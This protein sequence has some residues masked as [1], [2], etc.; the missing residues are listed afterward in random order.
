[1]PACSGDA[2]SSGSDARGADRE[3]GETAEPGNGIAAGRDV[4]PGDDALVRDVVVGPGVD[5][6]EELIAFVRRSIELEGVFDPA[7]EVLGAT[8]RDLETDQVVRSEAQDPGALLES[9]AAPVEFADP[10][11]LALG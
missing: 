9:A 8:V 4:L 2:L 7:V 11:C 5:G 6:E 3:G 10:G 1:M